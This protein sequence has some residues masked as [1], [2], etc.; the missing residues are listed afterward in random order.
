M[1]NEI[2]GYVIEG[3]HGAIWEALP[4][5]EFLLAEIEA[6]KRRCEG[7]K[8]FLVTCYNNTWLKL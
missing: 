8:T 5:L 2:Q 1:T 6:G 7:K 3:H 4:T